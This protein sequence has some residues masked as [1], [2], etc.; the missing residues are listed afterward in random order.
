L[1]PRLGFAY[2]VQA[3]GTKSE[4]VLVLGQ[5]ATL[6]ASDQWFVPNHVADL[7][8]DLRLPSPGNISQVLAGLERRG[9][10]RRRG[11]GSAGWTLTPFGRQHL[12]EMEMNI[13]AAAVEREELSTR[14][15]GFANTRH[16]LVPAFLAPRGWLPA[17]GRFLQQHEFETNVFCMTRF[18]S[19]PSE[20]L[21]ASIEK[22]GAALALHRLEL[23]RADDA[24]IVDDLWGNV[25]AYMWACSYG[26][27]FF[28]GTSINLNLTI[29]VGA[30]LA[31]GRRC[32]LLR[33]ASVEEMPTDLVGQIYKEVR[34]D[35]LD[36]VSSAVHRW[37]ADDLGLGRCT[38]CD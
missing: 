21:S 16:S 27:A 4:Q 22:A 26:L 33:D 29:E 19:S 30:M 13:D 34:L 12:V 36:T 5:L 9:L 38:E 3:L 35:S 17:I 24:Q 6:H 15:A 37:A 10:V 31:T 25:A 1:K 20:P 7:F 32:A 18:P 23:H 2:Q 28:E 11:N 8:R 14:G